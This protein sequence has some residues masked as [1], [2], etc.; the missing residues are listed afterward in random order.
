VAYE[1][2]KQHSKAVTALE[3]AA[4]VEPKAVDAWATL[5]DVHFAHQDYKAARAAL[6]KGLVACGDHPALLEKALAVA[7]V[8]ADTAAALEYVE[9]ELKVVPDHEQAW[10]NL[11]SLLLLE[12]Q[13][14]ASEQA[15]KALLKRNP[16]S[17]QA[18]FHL[19]N[20][21]EAVPKD[22]DAE[23]AYK[24]AIALAPDE[25]KPLANLG[26]LLVQGTDKRKH[27]EAVTLLEKSAALAP[28]G[29]LRPRYNLALAFAR[30]GKT[31]KALELAR[32]V[33][34][35]A[36]PGEPMAAEAKKLEANLL[37]QKK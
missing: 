18:W 32:A 15:A 11:A 33:K 22:A 6:D 9:R 1:G 31:D 10:L 26:A 24:K 3:K 23:A 4:W 14:D 8:Q 5:A 36:K 7:M 17:W 21:Y 37:E 35:D 13:V 16:K 29:E 27:A 2:A 28:K 34:K 12:K 30:L 20:L 19:G 25:W